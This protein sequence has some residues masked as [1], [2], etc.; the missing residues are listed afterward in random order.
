MLVKI[1]V[2]NQN[3]MIDYTDVLVIFKGEFRWADS[4]F[5]WCG[6]ISNANILSFFKDI[7]F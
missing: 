3:F 2:R 4:I 5:N 1:I 7:S 6:M